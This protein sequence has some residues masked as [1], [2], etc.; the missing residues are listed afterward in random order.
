MRYRCN[1]NFNFERNLF[2]AA[3]VALIWGSQPGCSRGPG[4]H[5]NGQDRALPSSAGMVGPDAGDPRTEGDI[6]ASFGSLQEAGRALE[7]GEIEEAAKMLRAQGGA[8]EDSPPALLLRARFAAVQGN[9]EEAVRLYHRMTDRVPE[10]E[11]QRVE[12]LATVLGQ[13]GRPGEAAAQLRTLLDTERGLSP[14]ARAAIMKKRAAWLV[15]AEALDEG[16]G[17]YEKAVESARSPKE[18]DSLKLALAK[19]LVLAKQTDRAR[20]LL[21]NLAL[22]GASGK[23]MVEARAA[24]KEG[25]MSP[26]WSVD[27]RLDRANRLIGFR[28]FDEAFDT[29]APLQSGVGKS[30]GD[31]L[32]AN[33][34]YKR[35]G[36]YKEAMAALKP[37]ASGNGPHADEA[38]FLEARALSR[39]DRDGEAILAY[40]RYARRTN[41]VNRATE[42]RFL[43]ARLEFYLGR[44]QQALNAIE[45]LVGTGQ[46]GQKGPIKGPGRKRD[47][48]FLAGLSAILID[49]PAVAESHLAAASKGSDNAEV[50]A[51]NAYWLAVARTMGNQ[52]GAADDLRAICKEDVTG[53]YARFAAGRLAKQNLELGPC[54]L[55]SL[56]SGSAS[57]KASTIG[58]RILTDAELDSLEKLST[59]A[60]LYAR[61]GFYRDAANTL[62][63]VEKR[64]EVALPDAEWIA[65]YNRLDAPHFAIRR[66]AVALSWPPKPEER[67]LALAAYPAP[68]GDLVR[69]MEKKHGL[70]SLLLYAIARK[71]SLFDP[72]AVS[73]VGA[74]GLM[75]MMPKTY[76]ANRKR[77]G[78]PRLKEGELPG[79][80]DSIVVASEEFADLFK[81]FNGS[82]PLAIMAYNAG[83]HSV[84]RWLARSGGLPLDM[85]V[86]KAGFVETR[87]YVRRVMKNLVRYRQLYGEPIPEL[88]KTA[89]KIT[90][91]RGAAIGANKGN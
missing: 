74:M 33:I 59:L 70:P 45:Q 53:W 75:Q 34:L 19:T 67:W 20:T 88:P 10:F 11:R 35:R 40:R 64:G 66:A 12:D 77:A 26:R 90:P 43:A 25:G 5:R 87:N 23:V 41:N 15:A 85:F 84:N 3:L 27:E 68:L 57:D 69:D 86:E 73:W 9:V 31:W 56:A 8:E 44:H 13:A 61:A 18:R 63:E 78:L 79:P 6:P 21:E 1:Y 17:A 37:I 49:K 52:K 71:E 91:K 28:S 29:L 38:R 82:L 72:K 81:Q 60:A 32:R 89:E 55:S 76:E 65:H 4:T 24:L 16:V 42:A 58:F 47:A 51:R 2:I 36:H 39:V 22:K 14:E 62:S 7:A 46:G 80:E 50:L 30:E 83:P 48:H 54:E